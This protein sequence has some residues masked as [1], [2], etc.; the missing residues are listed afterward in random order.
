[1][2]PLLALAL[3]VAAGIGV[4]R[5]PLSLPRRF[6]PLD[7][8]LRAGAPFVALGA[9]LGPALHVLDAAT[10][11]ALAPVTALGIGWIGASVG[12]RLPWRVLRRISAREWRSGAVL[13]AIVFVA[14]ALAAWLLMRAVPALGH[15]WRPGSG[16]GTVPVALTLGA[17]AAMST[18]MAPTRRGART[19]RLALTGTVTAVALATLLLA[20]NPPGRGWA[21]GGG[22]ARI[23][24]TLVIAALVAGTCDWLARL[25]PNARDHRLELAGVVLLGSAAGLA[26]GLSPFLICGVAAALIAGRHRAGALVTAWEPWI[27]AVLLVLAGAMLRVPTPWILAAAVLLE[28][29]R[30]ATRWL[31]ARYGR[32]WPATAGRP[33]VL[34]LSGPGAIALALS[35]EALYGGGG[36]VLATVLAGVLL[37]QATAGAIA[38][39]T[40]RPR[41]LTAAPSRAEVT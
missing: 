35:F 33:A 12:A 1:V 19:R 20:L 27:Y 36:A 7:A 34:P 38:E 5:L 26:G 8:V 23:A 9:L 2:H 17:A 41:P 3:V 28:V 29:V 13:G 31:P 21:L 40:A 37:A 11:R 4:T 22:I 15:A 25:R 24:A 16:G 18:G 10:L 6:A 30:L 14:A 32:L 39:L